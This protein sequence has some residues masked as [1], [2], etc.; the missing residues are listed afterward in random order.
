[1]L[2]GFELDRQA[3]VSPSTNSPTVTKPFALLF[4]FALGYE[5][6]AVSGPLA[7]ATPSLI[8][9]GWARLYIKRCPENA[10]PRMGSLFAGTS[11]CPDVVRTA[12]KGSVCKRGKACLNFRPCKSYACY[13]HTILGT[14]RVEQV[15]LN[16]N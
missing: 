7:G 6:Q 4:D 11:K 10:V 3:G 14:R 2:S 9:K 1:M 15:P 13:W 5:P 16:T 12:V 8:L